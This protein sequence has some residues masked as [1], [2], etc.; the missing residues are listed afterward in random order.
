MKKV[1]IRKIQQSKDR[2][3]FPW[4]IVQSKFAQT[5]GKFIFPNVDVRIVSYF[6]HVS[7]FFYAFYFSKEIFCQLHHASLVSVNTA[8]ICR[9]N[10]PNRVLK[11][12][13]IRFS[14]PA[15]KMQQAHLLLVSLLAKETRFCWLLAV[16]LHKKPSPLPFLFYPSQF[17]RR[18][19]FAVRC[20]KQS[21]NY[22]RY[23]RMKCI[24]EAK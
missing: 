12:T 23:L 24:S 6:A 21:S 19:Y 9:A 22:T 5:G 7:S 20:T 18:D 15:A 16:N 14:W 10:C 1:N 8:N 2:S 13:F 3:T 11:E 17:L 4:K